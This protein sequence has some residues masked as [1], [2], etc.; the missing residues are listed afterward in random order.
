MECKRTSC[1]T[2]EGEP[3]AKGEN[4]AGRGREHTGKGHN[5]T[6]PEQEEESWSSNVSANSSMIATQICNNE[7]GPK[8][9]QEVRSAWQGWDQQST[10]LNSGTATAQ[11]RQRSKPRA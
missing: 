7:E 8:T 2:R 6:V 10:R 1:S 5:P 11:L 9:S 3:G 4:K